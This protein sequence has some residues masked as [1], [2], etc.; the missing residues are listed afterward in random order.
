MRDTGWGLNSYIE[1]LE[2]GA[3]HSFCP[4]YSSD[5]ILFFCFSDDANRKHILIWTSDRVRRSKHVVGHPSSN[6]LFLVHRK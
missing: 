6:T 1:D 5:Q 4:F 3:E 2:R